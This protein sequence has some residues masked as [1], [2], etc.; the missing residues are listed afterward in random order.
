MFDNIGIRYYLMDLFSTN[1]F[2]MANCGVIFCVFIDG[3]QC[4][5]GGKI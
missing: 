1:D 4:N 3:V 2:E 5:Y